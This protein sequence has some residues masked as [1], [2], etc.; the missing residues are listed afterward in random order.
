MLKKP[1]ILMLLLLSG[2]DFEIDF[3][4]NPNQCPDGKCPRPSVVHPCEV[5][6]MNL[7]EDLRMHNY[8]GGS[9]V[10]ASTESHL[11]WLGEEEWADWWRAHYSGGESLSGLVSKLEAN[12]FQYAYTSSGDPAFL[13]WCNRTRRGAVIFYKPSHSINFVGWDPVT[14]EAML[15]DNNHVDHYERVPHDDFVRGWKGYGGV[16][17]TVIESPTPPLMWR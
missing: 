10:H 15:L 6:A 4:D 8:S 5:P 14:H 13:D 1:I 11:R 2:C 16:A 3:G 9:C 7:P 17:V 12:G